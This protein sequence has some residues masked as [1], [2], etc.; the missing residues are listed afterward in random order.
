MKQWV[1]IV[2]DPTGNEFSWDYVT[3]RIIA[4]GVNVA[5]VMNSSS[6]A[7]DTSVKETTLL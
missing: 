2:P 1:F 5:F 7:T 6:N 4:D 3:N